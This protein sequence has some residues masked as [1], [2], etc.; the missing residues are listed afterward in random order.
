MLIW[1]VVGDN[2][3]I[4]G[5]ITV[6]ATAVSLVGANVNALMSNNIVSEV[7]VDVILAA[8][9]AVETLVVLGVLY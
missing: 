1:D 4:R 3:Y 9:D 5:I 2:L 8:V 6:S 7:I